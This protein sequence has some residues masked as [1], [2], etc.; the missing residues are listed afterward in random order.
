MFEYKPEP[1][2]LTE[3]ERQDRHDRAAGQ[4]DSI[5]PWWW[6]EYIETKPCDCKAKSKAV[7]KHEMPSDGWLAVFECT[8]C[9]HRWRIYHE[10]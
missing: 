1:R 4:P 10:G 6:Q 5:I 9:Q 7:L 8:E 2:P 3:F